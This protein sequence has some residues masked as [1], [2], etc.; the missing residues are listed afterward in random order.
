MSVELS[1]DVYDTYRPRLKDLPLIY[2]MPAR[3][4]L[5]ELSKMRQ[6]ADY[7][8]TLP[9]MTGDTLAALCEAV[10]AKEVFLALGGPSLGL[11]ELIVIYQR[12]IDAWPTGSSADALLVE[13][14]SVEIL[15][16][17]KHAG[18]ALGALARFMVGIAAQLGVAPTNNYYMENWIGSLGYLTKDA[19]DYYEYLRGDPVWL[20]IDLGGEPR[21]MTVGEGRRDAIA[22]PREIIWT[23]VR[24]DGHVQND[25]VGSDATE[26]GLRKALSLIL[27]QVSSARPLLVDLAL[28]CDLLDQGIEHWPVMEVDG[29]EVPLSVDC[30]PRLRWSQRRREDRLYSRLVDRAEKGVWS[31]TPAEWRR[32]D[33]HYACFL[34]GGSEQLHRD[35]LRDLL[36]AGA[37]FLVWFPGGLSDQAIKDMKKAVRRV[38][39][40]AR[41]SALPDRLRQL[42]D[43]PAIIWDDPRGR[44][45]FRLPPLT[46]ARSR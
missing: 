21:Q 34:G 15:Q 13:A 2:V 41:R 40:A 35:L 17:R 20:V 39:P 23:S 25:V 12:V 45:E 26:P 8:Q 11:G 14:A 18:R 22:W 29:E 1:P 36:R 44:G 7:G 28:P 4:T 9:T 32:N 37:G 46:T 10:K 3:W 5:E 42:R 24:R 31:G 30:C 19:T 6:A 27:K 38:P 33:P 16:S 43:R